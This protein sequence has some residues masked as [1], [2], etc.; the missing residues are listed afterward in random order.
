MR[1]NYAVFYTLFAIA[2]TN[3][4]VTGY[5]II[6]IIR[7]IF[8][9]RWHVS[10]GTVY[11]ILK[12]LKQIGWIKEIKPTPRL[13]Q[14]IEIRKKFYQ[15]TPRGREVLVRDLRQLDKIISTANKIRLLP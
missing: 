10:S 4:D 5:D 11:P 12:K 2:S 8:S 6:L 13:G 14:H 3:R 9:D 15:I 7:H 1:L